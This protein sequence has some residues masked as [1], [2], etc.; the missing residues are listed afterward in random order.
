MGIEETPN[1]YEMTA[2]VKKWWGEPVSPDY[3]V[4]GMAP[5]GKKLQWIEKLVQSSV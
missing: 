1:L 3:A 2:Q 5:F 4:D